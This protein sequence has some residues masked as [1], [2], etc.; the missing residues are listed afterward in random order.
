MCF[1]VCLC[2]YF[3]LLV[4]CQKNRS[5]ARNSSRE[6]FNRL[7]FK[8][9]LK[10]L[11]SKKKKLRGPEYNRKARISHLQTR[12]LLRLLGRKPG[13]AAYLMEWQELHWPGCWKP[14]GP[15]D[16]SPGAPIPQN[17]PDHLG[18]TEA[19]QPHPFALY[20][21]LL[22]ELPPGAEKK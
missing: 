9:C 17:V 21:L 13:F 14:R 7:L 19:L 22:L 1:C 12:N 2:L 15:L 10:G 4:I 18:P 20:H 3:K 16:R 6:S 5:H 8:S 11:E